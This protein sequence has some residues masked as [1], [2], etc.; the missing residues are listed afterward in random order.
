[1]N[2][3]TKWLMKRAIV[4]S[5]YEVARV[6]C[7]IGGLTVL[8]SGL[9]FFVFSRLALGLVATVVSGQV[10]HMLWSVIIIL[11]GV[12]AYYFDG[13]GFPWGFGPILLIAAGLAGILAHL[14]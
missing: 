10:K 3:L 5:A 13:G 9:F 2:R 14:V 11:I 7:I 8:A 6:L 4:Q 1:M 12:L